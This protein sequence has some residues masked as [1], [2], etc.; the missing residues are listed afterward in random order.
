MCASFGCCSSSDLKM[1]P[2]RRYSRSA[3]RS[4]RAAARS[5]F[6]LFDPRRLVMAADLRVEGPKRLHEH[7]I[8]RSGPSDDDDGPLRRHTP[9]T[10][11]GR[12]LAPVPDACS[13]GIL[14]CRPHRGGGSAPISRPFSDAIRIVP[15]AVCRLRERR[16]TPGRRVL[17]GCGAPCRRRPARNAPT[18]SRLCG[19]AVRR[20]DCGLHKSM[21]QPSLACRI[22]LAMN[23]SRSRVRAWRRGRLPGR[24]SLRELGVV[25]RAA[26]R[27]RSHVYAR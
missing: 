18:V 24:P 10:E 12:L 1:A 9:K 23:S 3:A 17:Q 14:R 5:L 15:H 2:H 25:E 19:S 26:R 7:P 22:F 20:P 16:S 4:Q 8:G 11:L 6:L 21:S 27:L 13:L